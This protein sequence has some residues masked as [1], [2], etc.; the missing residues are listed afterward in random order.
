MTL[1]VD[2]RREI[3]QLFIKMMENYSLKT[4]NIIKRYLK[5]KNTK[6]IITMQ[7]NKI[8]TIFIIGC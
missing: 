2:L 6:E 7:I 8:S 3:I 5:N 1:K 4:L